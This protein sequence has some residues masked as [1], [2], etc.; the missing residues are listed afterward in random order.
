MVKFETDRLIL[1]TL[2]STD[3]D[4][5]MKF[6]GDA[7]VMK[8]C[9]GAGTRERELKAIEFYITLQNQKGFSPYIVTL[10]EN[11]EV[12]GA[13]GFN[14]T[15]NDNEIELIYHFAKKYWGKGYATEASRACVNYACSNL[16]INKII[17]SIDPKNKNSRKI[18][19]KIGFE[20]KHMRWFK[21]TKQEEPYFELAVL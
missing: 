12:I 9:G 19:E 11:N 4:A 5:V 16:K 1:R 10:K 7:E 13:C 20:Y 17:A 21:D 15:K 2:K 3:V 6:W 8:Y 14:P 18:L